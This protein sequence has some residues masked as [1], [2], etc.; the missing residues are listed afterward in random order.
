TYTF[1][2]ASRSLAAARGRLGE[3]LTAVR[4]EG[5]LFAAWPRAW[6]AFERVGEDAWVEI[7]EHPP[8]VGRTTAERLRITCAQHRGPLTDCTCMDMVYLLGA[9]LPAVAAAVE[10][11][12]GSE[13]SAAL[14]SFA[15]SCVGS[16]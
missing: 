10:R 5:L 3:P 2:A 16:P 8:F 11:F 14:L 9:D 13:R 7:T 1:A 6:L 15:L 12:E 4:R